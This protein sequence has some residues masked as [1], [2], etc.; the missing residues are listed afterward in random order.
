M[1][2]KETHDGTSERND[3]H[4][5]EEN[6]HK[7]CCRAD[8]VNPPRECCRANE[9]IDPRECCRAD[10]GIDP[11]ECCRANEGIDPRECC[12]VDEAADSGECCRGGDERGDEGDINSNQAFNSVAHLQV[13]L[14]AA[15]DKYVRLYSEF[16]NFKKRA[17]KERMTLLDKANEKTLKELLPIIDDFERSITALQ[18]KSD[19][20]HL[21]MQDG[22]KLIHDKLRTFLKK[23][24][25]KEME[26]EHGS[27]FNTD[28]HEAIM[29][30]PVAQP[31]VKGKIITVIEKG[32]FLNEYVLRFAKVVIGV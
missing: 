15:N 28:F 22:I 18:G 17:A 12:R 31:D 6:N 7:K 16:D 32:Y 5:Y 29:Q 30:Q 23:F 14:S 10:E 8:E 27:E 4:Q 11:R 26:L 1:K 25:V 19:D 21:A 13:L 24:G 9:G 2:R 3:H 20:I